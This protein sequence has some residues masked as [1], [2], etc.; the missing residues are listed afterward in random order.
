MGLVV[1]YIM[2]DSVSANND[3]YYTIKT[4]STPLPAFLY[5]NIKIECNK[6]EARNIHH[7]L[8]TAL[9]VNYAESTWALPVN[10]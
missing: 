10:F 3:R 2:P 1:S 9:A 6:Q 5:D 4:I 7:C 8:K